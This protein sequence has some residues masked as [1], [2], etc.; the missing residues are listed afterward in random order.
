MIGVMSAF[1]ACPASQAPRSLKRSIEMQGP[2][3]CCRARPKLLASSSMP[4]TYRAITM[5][6]GDWWVG[7]IE[8]VAGVNAQERTRDK[9]L[10]APSGCPA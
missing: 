9:L 8:E 2:G 4:N 7:W 1:T 5:K 3:R 10:R 6:R